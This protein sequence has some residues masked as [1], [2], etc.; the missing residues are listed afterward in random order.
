M[1][2]GVVDVDGSCGMM[3]EIGNFIVE[4]VGLSVVNCVVFYVCMVVSLCNGSVDMV[5][6][7]SNDELVEVVV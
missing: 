1:F 6:C 3:Y 2:F 7:F 5:L 4:W